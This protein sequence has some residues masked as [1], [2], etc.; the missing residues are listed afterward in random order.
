MGGARC[1][2]YMVNPQQMR[3]DPPTNANDCDIDSTGKYGKPSEVPTDMTY[4]L[5]RI[6]ASTVWRELVDAAWESGFDLDELPH[7]VILDYDK[8]FRD[9]M[10]EFERV[11]SN[12]T[13]PLSASSR[14]KDSTS[15]GQDRHTLSWQ[16]HLGQFALHCRFCRLHRPYLVRG[17]QE[18]QYAYSRMVCLKSAR[19]V[20]ELGKIMGEMDPQLAP[21]KFW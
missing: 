18:P 13:N 14:Q 3:V 9:M 10:T 21:S 4:F 6:T 20:I 1:E 17:S 8:K 19:K 11:F 2:T 7:H 15:D 12:T 5:F 16:R